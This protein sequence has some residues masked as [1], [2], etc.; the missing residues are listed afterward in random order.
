MATSNVT[1]PD[2]MAHLRE[3]LIQGAKD[4]RERER[5]EAEMLARVE[6]AMRMRE[7]YYSARVWP[8]FEPWEK[9]EWGGEE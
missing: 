4:D 5:E 8:T 1:K 6:T 9:R 3:T 2:I 7:R